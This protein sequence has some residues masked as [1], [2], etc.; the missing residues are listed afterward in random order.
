MGDKLFWKKLLFHD[1]ARFA[2]WDNVSRPIT[3]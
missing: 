3:D 2:T 1:V